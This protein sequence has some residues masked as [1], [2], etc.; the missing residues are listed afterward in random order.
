M[1]MQHPERG[2]LWNPQGLTI[3]NQSELQVIPEHKLADLRQR[4]VDPKALPCIIPIQGQGELNSQFWIELKKQL[5]MNNI[6]FL[7]D[8]KQYQ[9][10]LEDSGEYFNMSSEQFAEA[11][12]PYAQTELLIQEAV[13]LSAE[14]K[15]GKVKLSEPRNSTKDRAVCLSYANYI[16][17]KIEN[18]WN[19]RE[20]SDNDNIDDINLVF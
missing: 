18:Q 1:E 5:E 9:E 20:Q 6:K 2:A 14:Y 4:T 12:L 15:E 10:M 13:N 7:C 19:K 17:T 11:M 3:S 8:A 16:A